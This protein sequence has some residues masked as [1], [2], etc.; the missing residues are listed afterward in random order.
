MLLFIIFLGEYVP[1][2]ESEFSLVTG[3]IE[4]LVLI[5]LN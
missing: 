4:D 1:L 3:V 5:P 2:L